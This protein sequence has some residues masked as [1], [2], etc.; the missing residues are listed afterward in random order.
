MRSLRDDIEAIDM[1]DE[2]VRNPI[3]TNQHVGVDNVHRLKR[4][5][6]N[7]RDH[8]L[9]RLRDHRPDLHAR[10]LAGEL[11]PH[12]AMINAGLRTLSE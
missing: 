12:R 10:V 2:A 5:D 3:G 11:S 9:R 7:S 6:G 8:A 1:I 4:R